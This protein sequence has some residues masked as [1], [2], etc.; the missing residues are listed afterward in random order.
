[1]CIMIFGLVG[2]AM[3]VLMIS[4]T[5]IRL[6]GK[7]H[8]LIASVAFVDMMQSANLI[9][10]VVTVLSG[11]EWVFGSFACQLNG[12]L[13][14]ELVLTSMLNLCVI[15]IN[16]YVL[17]VRRSWYE[18]IFS[19][20]NQA[21]FIILTWVLPLSFSVPPL[22][23]W[24]PY[25]FRPG[26]AFCLFTFRGNLSY[27][28]T[29]VLTITSNCLIII[30]WCYYK[31]YRVVRQNSR[32][33]MV[34][35]RNQPQ[36]NVEDVNIAKTLAMVILA[37]IICYLPAT[38]INIIELVDEQYEIPVWLDFSSIMLVLLNQANNPLIYGI[39]NRQY[40]VAL[41]RLLPCTPARTRRSSQIGSGNSRSLAIEIITGVSTEVNE[42]GN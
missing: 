1:M 19:K 21:L 22:F 18:Q 40:R 29:M 7:G 4:R 6:K 31:I 26:K 25:G 28:L 9:F 37:Y 2:N 3:V 15:S 14:T 20:R 35:R 17:I 12:F 38:A 10:M 27:A 36:L 30:V 16:R 11:D 24:A 23:G 34:L 33:V 32:R 39:F 5:R 41:R 8:A 42:L 13:T